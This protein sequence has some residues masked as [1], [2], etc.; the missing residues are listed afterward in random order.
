VPKSRRISPDDWI[1][2]PRWEDFQ[3][4]KDRNP[5]WIKVYARLL[6]NPRWLRLS[7]ASRAVLLTIWLLYSQELGQVQVSLLHS[8]GQ[9][10]SGLPQLKALNDAGFIKLSASKPLA[11]STETEKEKEK[12]TL[13]LRK[14]ADLQRSL[15]DRAL[16]LAASYRGPSDEFDERLDAIEREV[17]E[18]LT[19]SQRA[20]LWEIV[21]KRLRR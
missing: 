21:W 16:D 19:Y 9:P 6:H 8:Y 5:T 20:Q 7:L 2:V 17:G 1:I 14:K 12:E 11:P 15:H 4:Y 13:Q 3:H 10:G 18:Q